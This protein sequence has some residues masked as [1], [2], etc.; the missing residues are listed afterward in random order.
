MELSRDEIRSVVIQSLREM[1]QQDGVADIPEIDDGIEP[2]HDLG[3]DS[4][5]GVEFACALSDKLKFHIPD[6]INP[7]VDDEKHRARRVGQIVELIYDLLARPQEA[8]H[9]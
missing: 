9:A 1:L 3:R 7:F 6:E 8:N 2:I 5:D 4:P